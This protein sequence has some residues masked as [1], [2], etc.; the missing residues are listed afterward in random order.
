MAR[1][2]LGKKQL[3]NKVEKKNKVSNIF[4]YHNLKFRLQFF[5]VRTFIV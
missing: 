2:I 3:G 1:D 4:Q 5:K